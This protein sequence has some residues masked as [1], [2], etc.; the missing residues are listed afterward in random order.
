MEPV[1]SELRIGFV[2]KRFS[3]EGGQFTADAR[4]LQIL[5]AFLMA[6]REVNDKADGIADDLL[7]SSRLVFAAHDT[8]GIYNSA[9]RAAVALTQTSFGG[10]GVLG[11]VGPGI[12]DTTLATQLVL[13]AADVLH[14]GK[15]SERLDA[16]P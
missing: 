8:R 1:P 16:H 15:C 7:P 6:V 3:S 14:V 10:R 4:G 11:V 2:F 13:G 12:P 9:L 5:A